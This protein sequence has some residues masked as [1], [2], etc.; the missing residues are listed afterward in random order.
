[1]DI[2]FD[3]RI[4]QMP[5]DEWKCSA[6]VAIMSVHESERISMPRGVVPRQPARTGRQDKVSVARTPSPAKANQK[7][8]ADGLKNAL[9]GAR[10][11][12]APKPGKATK[13]YKPI[14]PERVAEIL[15]R[16]NDLYPDVNCAL[17][18]AS[19]WELLVATILSAQSTDVNVNRVTPE[20]FQEISDRPSFCRAE[21]RAV[22]AGRALDRIFSEQV[23]VGGW[24]SQENRC[25]VWRNRSG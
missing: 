14:A 2:P 6:S 13:S 21:S 16:L 20:L 3:C 11:K 18:H 25:G 5:I 10:T 12:L 17:T 1:M 23:E 4:L 19:A 24:C 8:T 22:G 9:P 15:K 7:K